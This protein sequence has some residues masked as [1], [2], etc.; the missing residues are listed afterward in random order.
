M[1]SRACTSSPAVGLPD[2]RVPREAISAPVSSDN[3]YPT[4]HGC[5]AVV[6]F[7]DGCGRSER[8]LAQSPGGAVEEASRPA[9]ARIEEAP[10]VVR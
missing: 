2:A 6:A 8:L 4:N 1:F 9:S 10:I 7:V 3:L 5:R